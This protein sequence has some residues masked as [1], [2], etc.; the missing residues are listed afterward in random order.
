MNDY[1]SGRPLQ[2]LLTLLVAGLLAVGVAVYAYTAVIAP[3]F[4]KVS[5]AFE[6]TSNAMEA[7]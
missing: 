3:A 4:A 7:R 6:Q 5:N 1:R 2:G